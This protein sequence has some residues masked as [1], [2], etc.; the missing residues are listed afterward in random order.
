MDTA[1]QWAQG[2]GAVNPMEGSRSDVLE[3]R[4]R[5]QKDQALNC[6]RCNSTNTKFCYYNNYSLSQP[7]Y[8]CKTC[9]RYWTA[10]GSLI[11]CLALRPNRLF[12]KIQ[13][14]FFAKI[15][16]GLYFLDRFN[17]LISKIIFKK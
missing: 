5:P 11:A 16:C 13:F 6:P 2:I 7:R 17:V 8:F 9:R 1:T 4:A 14:F 10:G 3:R 15:E 12:K